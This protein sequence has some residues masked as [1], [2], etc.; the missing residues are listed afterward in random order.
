LARIAFFAEKEAELIQGQDSEFR[1]H[2]G[3]PS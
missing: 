3:V 1:F 2:S